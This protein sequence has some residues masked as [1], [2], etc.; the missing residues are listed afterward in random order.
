MSADVYACVSSH[1]G[2]G[3]MF[4]ICT[5][6]NSLVLQVEGKLIEPGSSVVTAERLKN[7]LRQHFYR[8]DVTGTVRSALR[9][10]CI[11]VDSSKY[12]INVYHLRS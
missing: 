12:K 7:A 3:K 11:D 10:Y 4:N 1:S 9:N 5:S 8:D 6:V 2:C